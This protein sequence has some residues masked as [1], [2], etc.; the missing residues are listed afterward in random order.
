MKLYHWTILVVFFFFGCSD[1]A[2]K[3]H[4]LT[5][6]LHSVVEVKSGDEVVFKRKDAITNGYEYHFV[7]YDNG[8]T[9]VNDK[10]HYKLET[11]STD[12]Y[13]LLLDKRI[14]RNMQFVVT[15]LFDDVVFNLNN[16][17]EQYTYDCVTVNQK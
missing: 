10:D 7:V 12:T 2:I 9:V 11:N 14:V 5:C 3:E 13:S 4:E 8:M 16:R 1:A 17:G 15:K 6:V